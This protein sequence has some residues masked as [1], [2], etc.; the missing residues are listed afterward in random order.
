MN[1][2]QWH[3]TILLNQLLP[4]ANEAGEALHSLT[5]SPLPQAVQEMF[6]TA[7]DEA[8]QISLLEDKADQLVLRDAI[9]KLCA[10]AELVLTTL[11][12]I[13]DLPFEVQVPLTRLR[14]R[15]SVSELTICRYIDIDPDVTDLSTDTIK[16]AS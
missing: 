14:G 12:I 8:L 3:L 16:L 5:D 1:R 13:E 11:E 15:V 4:A 9:V 7:R 6:Q 2:T 10:T